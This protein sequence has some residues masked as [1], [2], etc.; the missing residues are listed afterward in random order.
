MNPAYELE[1]FIKDC[2]QGFRKVLI[3]DCAMRT[4]RDEFNLFP[5]RRVLD[6]IATGGLEKPNF[7]NSKI[8][9][10]N[11][12]PETEIMIDAWDFYA[13]GGTYGYI[14]FFQQPLNKRWTIKSFKKNDK[15]DSR[16]LPFQEPLQ[17]LVLTLN[18]G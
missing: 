5:A 2:S 13:G 3:W 9:E 14:A 11:P 8:W 18:R 15:V 1:D 6:F 10:N 12:T 7:Y 16:N 17:K 4:A